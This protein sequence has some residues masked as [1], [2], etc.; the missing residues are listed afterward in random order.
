MA[1]ELLQVQDEATEGPEMAKEPEGQAGAPEAKPEPEGLTDKHGQP[2]IARGKYERDMAAK[3]AEIAELKAQVDEAAKTE[4]GR[5]ELLERIAKLEHDGAESAINHKLELAG[6]V[7][8]K[9]ARA[10]LDDYEGDV[11]KLKE[12]CPYLFKQERQQTGSTGLAPM[13]SPSHY[14][15]QRAEAR[16]AA[17][18]SD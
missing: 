8:A 3:D 15:R 1:D 6:C 9:A 11:A 2:A 13:G 16:K 10:V 18:L 12:A 17:G 5:K 7:N 4:A 14:E